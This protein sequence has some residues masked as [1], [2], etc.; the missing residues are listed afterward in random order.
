MSNYR[1]NIS[2]CASLLLALTPSAV[3]Q[4][5]QRSALDPLYDCQ[6]IEASDERLACYDQVTES[7]KDAEAAKEI[8]TIRRADVEQVQRESFGFQLPSLPKLFQR[9]SSGESDATNEEIRS[10]SANVI[11]VERN[12]QSKR[13][14]VTLDNGQIWR[15]TDGK[16]IQYSQRVGVETATIKRAAMGSFKMKLD[17]GVAFRVTRVK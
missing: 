8:S 5:E 7:L 15:Q 17:D 1:I 12:S 16:R 6:A 13:L 14:T 3:A 4:E 9:N 11:N 10:V 2:L